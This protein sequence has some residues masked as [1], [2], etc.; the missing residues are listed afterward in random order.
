[1]NVRDQI[2]RENL[3]D[4]VPAQYV[5]ENAECRLF[6]T[7]EMLEDVGEVWKA[8][9]RASFLGKECAVG[10]IKR[11]ESSSS[12]TRTETVRGGWRERLS[13]SVKPADQNV[14]EALHRQKAIS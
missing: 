4:G 8:A 1:V 6:W 12:S 5:T 13:E 2:L 14:W 11:E 7:R 9:G 10:G 3:N